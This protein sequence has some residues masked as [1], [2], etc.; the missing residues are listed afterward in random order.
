[1]CSAASPGLIALVNKARCALA[2]KG[3]RV[4]TTG[5][6]SSRRQPPSSICGIGTE[7]AA[8]YLESV[9]KLAGPRPIA[10]ARR[11]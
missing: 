5:M 3:W 7:A 8:A 10:D 4:R 9:K 6:M 1:M 2:L 11:G